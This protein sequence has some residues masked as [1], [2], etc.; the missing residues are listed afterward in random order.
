MITHLVF[1]KMLP[2]ANG[3]SGDD[4]ALRLVE[5][6]QALPAQVP[7]LKELETGLDFS[8]S[9]ASFDVGLV[10]RFASK[11]DLETYRIHPEHQKVVDFVQQTTASRAVVDYETD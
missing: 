6:L 5:M 11:E 3:A 10:T 2:E 4:N 7:Q 8:N 9:P 1:F